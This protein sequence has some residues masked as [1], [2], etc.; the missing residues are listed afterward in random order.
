LEG[1]TVSMNNIALCLTTHDT[2][3]Y[4]AS[5]KN[6]IANGTMNKK[7]L[8]NLNCLDTPCYHYQLTNASPSTYY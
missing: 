4:L 8:P 1:R 6:W 5:S 2:L 7:M 3:A